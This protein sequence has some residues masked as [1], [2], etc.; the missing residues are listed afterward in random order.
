[1]VRSSI[2]ASLPEDIP[3][4][5]ALMAEAGLRLLNSE[6]ESLH[7]KYWRERPDWPGPRSFVMARG[8]EILAH[9][10]VVP[11]AFLFGE[12]RADVR[13]V[14][15]L[16]VIDW[17]ARPTA[18]G[19]GASLMKHLGQSTDA[20]LAIGGS[21]Q[22]LRLLPHLGF[23]PL[24]TATCYVR[25]LRPVRIL[26][27]SVH[28]VSRLLPRFARSVLWSLHA[29]SGGVDGWSVRRIEAGDLS[30]VAPLLPAP[31][32]GM[33]VLERGKD[34]FHYSLA[35]PIVPM[36]LY[37]VERGGQAR[38]YFL[39]SF[40]LRQ[41]RLVDYWVSSGDPADSRALVQCAVSQAKQ[42]SSCAELVAWASDVASRNSLLES[43]FHQRGV[44]S[45]QVLASRNPRLTVPAL[46][47]QMLDNDAA[48]LHG[49]R[50]E[51]WA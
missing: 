2:R 24:G 4:V 5:Q 16:H 14:R 29:P 44:L 1:L 6:P 8:E 46:R 27:S 12:G 42:H 25:P 36:E 7:W 9:A 22:T 45:V 18:V 10:G 23:R 11:G 21:D 3:A 41:A 31:I 51:F 48:Y 39:L 47:V 30:R 40:A 15:A 38:G 35:C 43:G 34:L 20:L 17:V 28:P 32:G 33:G 50:N 49:S 26:T 19:A 13:R 37:A